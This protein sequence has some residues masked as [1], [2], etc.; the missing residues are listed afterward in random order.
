MKILLTSGAGRRLVED[1]YSLQV[2]AQ[3]LMDIQRS[4]VE[5]SRSATTNS[6][7]ERSYG[8]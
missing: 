4:V 1:H 2:W 5:F 7:P 6:I 3:R 8:K